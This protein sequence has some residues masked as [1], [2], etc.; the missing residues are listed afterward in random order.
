MAHF[1]LFSNKAIGTII[2]EHFY[3]Y[4]SGKIFKIFPPFDTYNQSWL[5][6]ESGLFGIPNLESGFENP[7]KNPENSK[8]PRIGIGI[9]KPLKNLDKIP[10]AKY[11]KSRNP[12]DQDWD[13]RDFLTSGYPGIEIFSWDGISQQKA[14]SATGGSG[15]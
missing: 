13:F 3:S 2:F 8:I 12:G 1:W 15:P 4:V 11:R 7:E 6:D 9:L 10:S 5:R 14:T